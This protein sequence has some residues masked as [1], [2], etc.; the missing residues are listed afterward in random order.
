MAR[1]ANV[2]TARNSAGIETHELVTTKDFVARDIFGNVEEINSWTTGVKGE[3]AKLITCLSFVF[4]EW[5]S[6]GAGREI[7]QWWC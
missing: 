7:F 6:K 3:T 4:K 5:D 1:A 2:C